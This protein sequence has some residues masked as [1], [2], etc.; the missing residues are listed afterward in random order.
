MREQI[1][2]LY[3]LQ[4]IDT[5]LARAADELA[6]MDHGAKLARQAKAAQAE[7]EDLQAR[8]HA[9]QTDQRDAELAEKSVEEKIERNRKKAYGGQVANPK[10]LR[11]L[12]QE[13]QALE[14][15]RGSLDEKILIAMTE[16]EGLAAQVAAKE[17]EF[18][19]KVRD[20]KKTAADQKNRQAELEAET[21]RLNA[22]RAE[23]CP[24]LDAPKLRLYESLRPA[25]RNLAIVAL[26]GNTCS[27]CRVQLPSK[28]VE[29]AESFVE[30]TRCDS[31]GRILYG[32]FG[33][34][35]QPDDD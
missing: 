34:S 11:H 15:Q 6:K 13:T 23:L 27:G 17:E 10:E 14:R 35:H 12:E 25:M 19:Q 21:V 8:L 32:G 5:R 28:A 9:V 3:D 16:A 4:Q 22:E 29:R 33:K 30:I 20:Y 31:C 2:L 18:R 7:L 1:Q 24:R 26:D